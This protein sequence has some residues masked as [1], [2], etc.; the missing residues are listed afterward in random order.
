MAPEVEVQ[1]VRTRCDLRAFVLFPWQVYRGDP[2]WVPPLI[3]QRLDYLTPARNP[4][5]QSADVVLY[6]ARR[7]RRVLG[8]VAALAE[9]QVLRQPAEGVGTFGFFEVVDDYPVARKLL[10]AVREW[11]RARGLSSLRGPY[12]LTSSEAPGVLVGG[13]ACPPV[14][15]TAHTPPY[16]QTF[17]ERFGLEK[18]EDGYAWRVFRSQIG[19]RLQGVPEVFTRVARMARSRGVSVR[20]ARLDRWDEEVATAHYLFNTTLTHLPGYVPMPEADFRRFAA[21]LRSLLDPDLALFA[22]LD[23]RVVGFCVSIPDPNRALIHLNGRLFPLGWLKL[24]YYTRRIDVLTFKLMGVLPEYRFRGIEAVLF[25]EALQAMVAR[26]Y[27]WLE[28]SVTSEHNVLVNRVAERFGAE[29]YKHY[30]IYQMAV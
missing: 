23:G 1:E 6:L 8:T 4:V 18:Y 13:A 24:W 28:G 27:R 29:R 3:S 5:L 30:R 15:L 7:G 10:E 26:G 21:D 14:M 17:L 25:L 19:D 20:K 22:E 11:A 9:H 2:H 12:N 16:Y